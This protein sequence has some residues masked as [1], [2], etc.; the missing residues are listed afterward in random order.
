MAGP[1]LEAVIGL[2][3]GPF[4][5]GAAK[6]IDKSRQ[7]G[8]QAAAAVKQAS[9]A[10]ART[11]TGVDFRKGA[12]LASDPMAFLESDQSKAR[13]AARLTRLKEEER[14]AGLATERAMRA[15]ERASARAAAQKERN[16]EREARRFMAVQDRE[17]ARDRQA[18]ARA[19]ADGQR[20]ADAHMRRVERINKDFEKS[21]KSTSKQASTASPLGGATKIFAGFMAADFF[22]RQGMQALE[23]GGHIS[24]LA[25][26]LG[27][28]STALQQWDFA[29]KQNGATI[30]DVSRF[31]QRLAINRQ[32]ALDGNQEQIESFKTFG[33]SIDDLRNKRLEDVGLQI[34]NAFKSGDQQKMIADLRAIGGRSAVDLGAMFSAGLEDAFRQAPIIPPEAIEKIDV[35]GDRLQEISQVFTSGLARGIVALADGLGTV[36]EVARTGMAAVLGFIVGTIEPIISGFQEGGIT[37]VLKG[38]GE[39][40]KGNSGLET[41]K[42]W[43]AMYKE[44]RE[45]EKKGDE[46]RR[47]AAKKTKAAIM[48]GG[49]EDDESP[50]EKAKAER[51]AERLTKLRE[52][53]AEKEANNALI[54]LEPEQKREA[55]L[56]RRAD[57][58]R[59]LNAESSEEKRLEMQS[60][61]ADLDKELKTDREREEDELARSPML[62]HSV[63]SLQQMGGFLGNFAAAGISY[64][65]EQA[66]QATRSKMANHLESI[67]KLLKQRGQNW[68]SSSTEVQ[69]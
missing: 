2:N 37:G 61:L 6:V 63:N 45:L 23:Y 1:R 15:E 60:D 48:V 68:D 50:R 16:A 44:G 66:A 19:Y 21:Q 58:Q 10:A 25:E 11:F 64:G 18:Q 4:N 59:Q 54:G 27:V 24:D 17:R 38:I 46:E 43:M 49:G 26:S 30:D 34:G 13:K 9:T 8:A 62:K 47:A 42:E 52:K 20:E 56:K 32:K 28:G 7:M 5:N 33:V 14:E 51:E 53:V 55:L 39:A 65:P 40:T 22:R 12:G 41:A 29:A 3:A 57:L 36:I 69:Y 35:I 31:F 67:E